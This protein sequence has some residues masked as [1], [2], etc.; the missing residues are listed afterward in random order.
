MYARPG[1]FSVGTGDF[2]AIGR[3]IVVEL[4]VSCGLRP[5][6]HVLDIGCGVG[7]V[8]I[9]LTQYLSAEGRY[10]GFD[11]VAKAVRHCQERITPSYPSFRFQA[12]DLYNKRYNPRGR[13]RD[14]EYRFP[15]ADGTFDVVLA[16]SV[17]THL[18]PEGT[19]RYIAETARVLKPGGC[20][21]AT[22]FLLNDASTQAMEA[23]RSTIRFSPASAVHAV[24]KPRVP[25]A[26]V[27]FREEFVAGLYA[28]HGLAETQPTSYGAWSGQPTPYAGSQDLRVAKKSG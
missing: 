8:A 13:C 20:F 16:T 19:E 27:A 15:Y 5:D 21:L 9:P 10:E 6:H 12:A 18:L 23:G 2:E 26:A 17:F 25:E 14:H 4:Q 22:Y 7:R 3:G 11:P 1:L 28:R 24:H